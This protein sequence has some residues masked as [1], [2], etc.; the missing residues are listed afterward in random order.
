MQSYLPRNADADTYDDWLMFL[1][2]PKSAVSS[3]DALLSA[4]NQVK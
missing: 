1:I 2:K 4:T 3:D